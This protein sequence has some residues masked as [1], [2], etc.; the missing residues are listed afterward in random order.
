VSPRASTN[1]Q[2]WPPKKFVRSNN[3]AFIRLEQ[4]LRLADH[5]Y[6]SWKVWI[7]AGAISKSRNFS[8]C[9]RNIKN[10][11][12]IDNWGNDRIALPHHF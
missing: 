5:M 10:H 4:N 9:K 6:N 11:K 2:G 1:T 12:M 7:T 3:F 8:G